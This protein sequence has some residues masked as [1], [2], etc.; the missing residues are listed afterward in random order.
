MDKV[1][2]DAELVEGV[3]NCQ[4]VAAGGNK[5]GNNVAFFEPFMRKESRKLFNVRKELFHPR[6]GE[7][8]CNRGDE[9]GVIVSDILR[10]SAITHFKVFIAGFLLRH[11]QIVFVGN[12]IFAVT[13]HIV[14]L[15]L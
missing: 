15:L 4:R 9:G 6:F 14:C 12:L 13:C 11:M 8:V 1:C 2:N 5:N 10:D 3:K 7:L